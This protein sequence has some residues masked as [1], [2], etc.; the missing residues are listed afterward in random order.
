[1]VRPTSTCTQSSIRLVKYEVALAA[2]IA[3]EM[4]DTTTTEMTDTTTAGT[5]D[6]EEA[7]HRIGSP[8][9]AQFSED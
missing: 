4:K 3:R 1:M 5:R 2:G 7:R 9:F 8:G 6:T